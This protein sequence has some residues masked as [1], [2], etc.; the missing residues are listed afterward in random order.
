MLIYIFGCTRSEL[1]HTGSFVAA[2]RMFLFVTRELLVAAFGI[3]PGIEPRLPALGVL[4][5][6]HQTTRKVSAVHL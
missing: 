2:C 4:S 1:W 6:S 3:E 5:L